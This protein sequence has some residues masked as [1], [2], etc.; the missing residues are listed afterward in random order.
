MEPKAEETKRAHLLYASSFVLNMTVSSHS[1]IYFLIVIINWLFFL[2][3]KGVFCL[4]LNQKGMFLNKFSP[5]FEPV[6]SYIFVNTELTDCLL[7]L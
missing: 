1:L 7:A 2:L 4:Q 3:T 6:L 5:K